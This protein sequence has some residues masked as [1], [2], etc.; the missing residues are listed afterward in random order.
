MESA[1]WIYTSRPKGR[2]RAVNLIYPSQNLTGNSISGILE[3][4]NETLDTVELSYDTFMFNLMF[5][6]S[7]SGYHTTLSN[8]FLWTMPQNCQTK[9]GKQ[10]SLELSQHQGQIPIKKPDFLHMSARFQ[11][12]FSLTLFW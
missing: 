6:L 8:H 11:L 5:Q 9:F 12:W 3:I 10:K 7:L 1:I 4:P 2:A